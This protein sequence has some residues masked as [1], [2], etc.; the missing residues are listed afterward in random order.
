MFTG[1][2]EGVG[3]VVSISE[4]KKNKIAFRVL[5][6]RVP[7]KFTSLRMGQSLAVNGVCL[8]V[9]DKKKNIL[10]FHLLRETGRRT[11]LGFLCPG[12]SVNLERA[13]RVGSR[14]EGHFVLGHV[15]GVGKVRRILRHG[16]EKTIF[17]SYPL[18]LKRL[19]LPKGS[20]AVNGVSLTIGECGG[21]D[22]AV[23]CVSRTLKS[24][25]LDFLRSG[26]LVNLEADILIKSFLSK[27]K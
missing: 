8:T 20:V 25:N 15:D 6:A 17:I 16:T 19:I 23:H 26:G 5:A 3:T 10:Y 24:T 7:A 18:G 12:E 13:M 4:A 2:V 11:A 14:W 9:A 27:I 22:F 1:I 21:K